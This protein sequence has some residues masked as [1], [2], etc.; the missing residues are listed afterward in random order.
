M[1]KVTINFIGPLRLFLGVRTITIEAHNIDEVRTYLETHYGM[2]YEQKVKGHGMGGMES[3][4]G[5]GQFLLNGRSLKAS[6][7][8]ILKDGDRLDLLVT[9]AGG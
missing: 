9:A 6:E 1:A 5:H 8:I 7:K 2:V 4:W 3:I